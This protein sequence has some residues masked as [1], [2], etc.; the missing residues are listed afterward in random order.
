MKWPWV[1]RKLFD[2]SETRVSELKQELSELRREYKQLENHLMWRLT[3][4]APN[5]DMLPE[6]YRPRVMPFGG[7]P[8]QPENPLMDAPPKKD[9]V[10][11][12]V[13]RSIQQMENQRM[14]K[15]ESVVSKITPIS[16]PTEPAE[17]QD[18]AM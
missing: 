15:F 6:Q 16:Q 10:P 5:P 11:A 1:S 17:G 9:P 13:R 7:V 8:K 2:A 18:E 3:G 14:A 4:T 12:N